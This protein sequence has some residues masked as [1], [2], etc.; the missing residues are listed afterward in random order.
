MLN[1][2]KKIN[3]FELTYIVVFCSIFGSFKIFL[4]DNES[5]KLINGGL[6]GVMGAATGFLFFKLLE[7]QNIYLKISFIVIVFISS[8]LF[9]RFNKEK[10]KPSE[11]NPL[12]S[13]I[14][15]YT[16]KLYSEVDKS[17][18][19][20]KQRILNC[21]ESKLTQSDLSKLKTCAVCGYIAVLP[22]SG[23][24]FN[25]YN[26]IWDSVTFFYHKKND[27][28]KDVQEIYFSPDSSINNINFFEPKI[29][30]KFVKDINWKPIVTKEMILNKKKNN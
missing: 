26:D 25:C 10:T 11:E 3:Y 29:H 22:D 23:Y 12:N 8:A 21:P 15:N 1:E 6:L 30:K 4:P 27:W 14:G 18:N 28:L 13:V 24:C 7:K 17:M 9:L 5:L 19:K 2:K 16:N 20:G